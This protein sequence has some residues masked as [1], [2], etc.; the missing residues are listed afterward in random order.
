MY[1]EFDTYKFMLM[2]ISLKFVIVYPKTGA[3]RCLV[4][5]CIYVLKIS[6]AKHTYTHYV[7]EVFATI[8]LTLL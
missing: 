2:F 5:F 8:L 4:K 3:Q 1:E 6:S 7:C